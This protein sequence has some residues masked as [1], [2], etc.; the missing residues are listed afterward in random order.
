MS[1]IVEKKTIKNNK[2]SKNMY[3]IQNCQLRKAYIFMQFGFK[4]FF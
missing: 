3:E 1:S 4:I 2:S